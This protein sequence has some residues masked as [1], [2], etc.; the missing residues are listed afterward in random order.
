MKESFVQAFDLLH[1]SARPLKPSSLDRELYDS[2]EMMLPILNG[3]FLPGPALYGPALTEGTELP[4]ALLSGASWIRSLPAPEIDGT[5][6]LL[7]PVPSSGP[8]RT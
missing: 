3:F 4:L 5:G 2:S 1:T 6:G 8:G 7:L